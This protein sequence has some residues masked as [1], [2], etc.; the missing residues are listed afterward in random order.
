MSDNPIELS[1]RKIL[2][3]L[4]TVGVA[5]AGVGLG[6]SAY[7]SDEETFENNTLVAGELDLKVDWE[8]HYSDWKGDEV[9]LAEMADDIAEADYVLPAFSPAGGPLEAGVSSP[10]GP[11]A[12]GV[13]M[14]PLDGRPIALNFTGA[15]NSDEAQ[16]LFWDATAIEAFPDADQDGIQDAP[17][18]EEGE[19]WDICEYPADLD[20]VLDDDLRTEGSREEPLISIE[21]VKPGDFGEVTF[22][23]HLCDNPGYVWLTGNLVDANENGH[24]EP[25]A[26]DED[27]IGPDDTDPN[28]SELFDEEDEERV[29]LLDY[30]LT[31]IWYDDGRGQQED[32]GNNQ[33]DEITGDLDV[34]CALDTSGSLQSSEISDLESGVNT[35][36][37]ALDASSADAKIGTLEFGGGSVGN[38]NPLT[39]P[40]PDVTLPGSGDGDTPMAGAIEIADQLVRD[41]TAGARSGAEKVVVVFTDGGPNYPPDASYTAGGGDYSAG[42]YPDGTDDS[43]VTVGEMDE[44]RGV[45]NTVK[46]GGTTIVTVYVGEPGQDQAN[47]SGSAISKYTDLPTY[48]ATGE[49]GDGVDDGIASSSTD[50]FD[51]D[52]ADLETVAEELVEIVTIAEN[53]FFLGTLREALMALSGDPG[54]PLD[55]DLPAEEGGGTGRNCFEPSTTQYIGFEWWVPIN[56][57]NQIQTDS[58][59]FDIGFYTEQCRHNDGS[60]MTSTPAGE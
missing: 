60:G 34:V 2:A 22:S 55:G 52:V 8:E 6:T 42:P 15:E 56:H 58:V 7:F 45:A 30:V 14:E 10:I 31:R 54:Y 59:S 26:K 17:G 12:D 41:T 24:T 57:G 33:P 48:L 28:P 44:T 5:S 39:S 43:T 23:F 13:D 19:E 16:D 50:A 37:D 29:E 11:L 1:R 21:D 20:S 53:V 35:F 38:I 36:I 4:G 27:E 46:S 9:G 18:M 25:E 51:V 49:P 47:M 3:G 32:A 40:G